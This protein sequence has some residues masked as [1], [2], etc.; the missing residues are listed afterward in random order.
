MAT[1]WRLARRQRHRPRVLVVDGDL[2]RRAT[3]AVALGTRYVVET[4]A[5]ASDA[6]ACGGGAGFDLA[7]VDAAAVGAALPRLVRSLRSRA[8][9]IRVVV[10]AARRDFRAHHFV[11]MLGLDAV[12]ARRAPAHT[13]LDRIADLAPSGEPRVR[14]DR[15]VGRA[16]D[17]M[18]R[19]VINILDVSALAEATGVPLPILADRFR[20]DTGL[21]VDEYV[22]CVRVAVAE[23]LLRDTNLEMET[24]AELLGFGDVYELA[25]AFAALSPA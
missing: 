5:R 18:A 11:A 15:C 7:V 24:L 25:R 10:I 9:A 22:T 23:P 6:V 12:V 21:T 17:L 2:G 4:A 20:I 16:I 8:A 3:L 1:D 14:V 13:V 19:D